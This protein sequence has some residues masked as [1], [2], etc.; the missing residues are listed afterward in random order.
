MLGGTRF[1]GRAIVERLVERG[2]PTTLFHRGQSGPGLF[3]ECEHV[4]GDRKSSLA[5]LEGRPWDVVVDVSAYV[6]RD[7]RSAVAALAPNT[8]RC[9]FI[10][11]VSVYARVEG[12]GPTEEDATLPLEDP[13]TENVDASTYGGLKA[14]CEDEVRRGWPGRAAIVRP[15]LVAGPNDPTDRFT[16]WA[17]REGPTPAP[18]RLD[19]PVQVVDSRDLAAFC[20]GAAEQSL[21]GTFNVCGDSV[22]FG[23][24]LAACGCAPSPGGQGQPLVLPGDG[25][26]D[27]LFRCSNAKAKAA[28]L[29]LRPLAETAHDTRA[30][31]ESKGR[32]RLNTEQDG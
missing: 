8:G 2:H 4:L 20:V 14:L 10:S 31:W 1:V 9:V 16:Y 6:P 28:G 29:Q 17:V 32:P 25:S 18:A 3:P 23:E 26:A 24:M 7:V 27:F 15:G 11:T 13:E 19:Q 22:A 21:E 30:W 5:A 12:R